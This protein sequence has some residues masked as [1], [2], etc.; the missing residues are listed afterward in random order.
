MVL[1]LFLTAVPVAAQVSV[2]GGGGPAF[3]TGEDLEDV[4]GGVQLLGGLVF[5]LNERISLYAEGQWGTH[6]VDLESATD[7]SVKPSA[8]MAGLLLGLSGNEDAAV[9]PYVFGGLGL[10]SIKL[11]GT[12]GSVSLSIDDR[13]FGWQAGAGVGFDLLGLG[14]F[15]EGRYQ[16]ASFD[17]DSE[18]EELDFAIFSIIFGF[19][20]DLGGDN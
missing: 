3:P 15:L 18:F 19:S 5:D 4:D 20:F 8:V 7:G 1:G 6:D 14:S 10:Q 17:E 2:Y 12:E 11:E 13:T 9:S 16:S